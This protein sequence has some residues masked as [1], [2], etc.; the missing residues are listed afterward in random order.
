M[1]FGCEQ[2]YFGVCL[3]KV[4]LHLF[5]E[6]KHFPKSISQ[7]ATDDSSEKVSPPRVS[8]TASEQNAGDLS[9]LLD[10]LD[11]NLAE[12]GVVVEP[13]GLCAACSKPIVGRVS[14]VRV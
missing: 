6:M 3:I 10:A 11:R 14:S 13:K 4:P 5:D 1:D 7:P 9:V 2:V 8:S 12:Q